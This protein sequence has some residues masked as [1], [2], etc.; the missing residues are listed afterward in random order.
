MSNVPNLNP[1]TDA[2]IH[3]GIATM[4]ARNAYRRGQTDDAELLAEARITDRFLCSDDEML[5]LLRAELARV[6]G[7]T[8][9]GHVAAVRRRQS[10]AQTQQTFPRS[11]MRGD[12]N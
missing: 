3:R 11:M 2:E 9:G 8:K 10:V 4:A 1:M 12:F 7:Q 6:R 5:T